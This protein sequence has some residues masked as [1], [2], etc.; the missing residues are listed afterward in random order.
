MG[1]FGLV[2]MQYLE[3]WYQNGFLDE[4]ANCLDIFTFAKLL[5]F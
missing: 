3:N 2:A 1:R 4:C 5:H